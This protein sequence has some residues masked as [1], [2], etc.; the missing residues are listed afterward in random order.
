MEKFEEPSLAL[1]H[2]L[3]YLEKAQPPKGLSASSNSSL[4]VSGNINHTA[5][6]FSAFVNGRPG[7]CMI[8][9]LLL[10]AIKI[11]FSASGRLQRGCI[12][13]V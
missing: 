4:P 5:P 2:T 13:L 7:S 10:W 12:V 3:C 11:D 9:Q 1:S 6:N 8:Y